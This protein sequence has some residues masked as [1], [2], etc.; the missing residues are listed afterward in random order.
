MPL[1]ICF[2]IYFSCVI[3]YVKFIKCY[4]YYYFKRKST[5]PRIKALRW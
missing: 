4:S 2:I 3:N 5:K 1:F